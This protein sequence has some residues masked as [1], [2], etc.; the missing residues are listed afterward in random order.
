MKKNDTA[1]QKKMNPWLLMAILGA[2]VLS[3][4]IAIVLLLQPE[5]Q[6]SLPITEPP[7]SSVESPIED[8]PTE[9]TLPPKSLEVETAYGTFRLSGSWLGQ[10][11]T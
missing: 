3:I 9:S 4:P 1:K 11:R 2:V 8:I 6:P 5:G 7:E 10:M